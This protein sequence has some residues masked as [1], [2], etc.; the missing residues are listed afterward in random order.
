MYTADK[1]AVITC[2]LSCSNKMTIK[3]LKLLVCTCLTVVLNK[4]SV[5][6]RIMIEDVPN[7]IEKCLSD[8]YAHTYESRTFIFSNLTQKLNF[9]FLKPN[10]NSLDL[11]HSNYNNSVEIFSSNNFENIQH[12]WKFQM[13]V[14]LLE[15]ISTFE[16]I[17]ELLSQSESWDMRAKFL[18]GYFGNEDIDK[19]F[20]ICWK[21]YV[22]NINVVATKDDVQNI[23]TYFPYSNKSCHEYKEY[24]VLSNC[25]D[26]EKD[27]IFPQ[28]IPLDLHG[29]EV[30]YDII[31][32]YIQGAKICRKMDIPE[33]NKNI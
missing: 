11:E 6:A 10:Q 27:Q 12:S 21:Y 33:T 8:I 26:L 9:T 17:F 30:R 15:N 32:T 3:Y 22:V 23:Y 1:N 2:V 4:Y 13:Y 28:K 7:G 5:N 14:I 18:V 31:S 29:C 16:T 24:E 25:E 20:K 19:I